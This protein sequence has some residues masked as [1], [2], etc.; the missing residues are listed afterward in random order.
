[1]D[2]TSL[3]FYVKPRLYVLENGNIINDGKQLLEKKSKNVDLYY[4]SDGFFVVKLNNNIIREPDCLDAIMMNKLDN[5]LIYTNYANVIY[6]LFVMVF[7]GRNLKSRLDIYDVVGDE[8]IIV[9]LQNGI[10]SKNGM[11]GDVDGSMSFNSTCFMPLNASPFVN[12][13]NIEKNILEE[14]FN[15]LS[16]I[17]DN[18]LN[19]EHLLQTL[20]L[21]VNAMLNIKTGHFDI[22]IVLLWTSIEK[23]IDE[24]WEKLLD[25][26]DYNNMLKEKTKRSSEFTVNI[27]INE[28]FLGKIIHLELV[29][30]LD[31]ARKVRNKI[32]HGNYSL[33][34]YQGDING[35]F[36]NISEKCN[37]VNIAA[38]ELI[39][40]VYN[41]NLLTPFSIDTQ[42]Y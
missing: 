32:I 40:Y 1:M 41:L 42:M 24:L 11:K 21:Y 13:I 20:L 18:I 27:K 39:N 15:D 29:K 22:G 19:D 5:S 4:M 26:S 8:S 7:N 33:F 30:K 12:K 10:W 28:L 38:A 6:Y 16:N 14:C 35:T 31:K 37:I 36:T 9:S 2:T 17:L 25:D 3:G 23:I 34:L